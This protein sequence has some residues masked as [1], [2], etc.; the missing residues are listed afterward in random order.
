[1]PL[2][3]KLLLI[4]LDGLPR[5]NWPFMGSL[6]GWR[7][8]GEAQAWRM[9]SVLPSVS[10][11]CYA[12]MHTGA[13]PQAHGVVSNMKRFRVALPDVFSEVSKAGGR[14]GA[15]THAW[16]SELFNRYPFDPL[17][18]LEYDEPEGPIAHG[19]FHTMTGES[20]DNQAT[21]SDLDLFASL[22]LLSRRFGL[23][24]GI[25]H[26]CTLDAMGHRFGHDNGHMDHALYTVD[27]Q[28]A[29][30]LPLWREAGYEVIVTADH[31]QTMRGHHGGH[32]PEQQDTSLYYFG[33]ARGPQPDTLLSQLQLAPT[34]LSL[35]GVA[36]PET[37]AA[38]PFLS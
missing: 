7:M 38:A 12:S 1:M 26:T 2:S 3:R 11:P 33:S 18:D 25:L 35:L 36:V 31:G 10:A 17:R 27:A 32:E 34:I 23:D 22:T 20:R 8:S 15:V 19:R 28:L 30:F 13:P 4:V 37:M 6:E 5:R 16:W 21:P 29:M 14:T 24:Y 9:R